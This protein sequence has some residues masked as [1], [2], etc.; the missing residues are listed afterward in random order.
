MDEYFGW[1]LEDIRLHAHETYW[2]DLFPFL[3]SQGYILR[4][5]YHPGWEPVWPPPP[6][7]PFSTTEDYVPLPVCAA[8]QV[9]R[10]IG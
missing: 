5:R 10:F 7:I 4:P 6:G 9:S 1:T 2:R 8:C 3:E